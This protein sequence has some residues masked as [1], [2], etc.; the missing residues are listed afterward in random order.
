MKTLR[1]VDLVEMAKTMMVIPEVE[2]NMFTGGDSYMSFNSQAE[3]EAYL[4]TWMS[5]SN[6]V[7]V[8]I[9]QYSDGT[10]GVYQNSANT[11]STNYIPSG[12]IKG[13]DCNSCPNGYSDP[14]SYNGKTI[15]ALGHTH[16]DYSFPSNSDFASA[17][18]TPGLS[19]FVYEGNGV[20]VTYGPD[21]YYQ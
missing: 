2:L 7:E 11:A 14:Y 16:D 18:L 5:S 6:Y 4:N 9:F 8:S 21:N 1:K 17:A 15:I 13:T 12:T 20:Y 10:Y 3:M 19:R